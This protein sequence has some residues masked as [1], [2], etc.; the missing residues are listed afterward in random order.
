M[1]KIPRV[2]SKLRPWLRLVRLPAL[3]FA[4][5]A[6]QIGRAYAPCAL[7]VMALAGPK[8]PG[9]LCLLGA[10]A[11]SFAFFDFQPGLRFLA[12]AILTF[13][14]NTAFYD[15]R[16]YTRPDFHGASSVMVTTLVQSVYLLARPL[17]LTVIFILS[18][19]VQWGACRL[20]QPLS[21]KSS[22]PEGSRRAAALLLLSACAALIPL[23]S[24]G[25]SLGRALLSAAALLLSCACSSAPSAAALGLA[26][27]LAADLAGANIQM[28]CTAAFA[29]GCPL[30]WSA[31]SRRWLAGPLFALGAAAVAVL[32]EA[33]KPLVFLYET[34]SGTVLFLLLPR[35]APQKMPQPEPSLPAPL[36]RQLSQS[37]AAFR[38]LYDSFFRGTAPAPPEN[39]SVIFD[40]AAEQVCRKCV[41][42]STCWHQNYNATYNA[43]ND[44]CPALLQR[45]QALAQDFPIHFTSRCVHLQDF[46][47]ALN[48]ELRS[49]L[50][51]QQYH[52]RLLAARRLAQEQYAQ[53]GDLL[54][55]TSAVEAMT[56]TPIG[57]R[58]GSA[59]RPREGCRVCGDQ[60][61]V[62]E[63]GSTLYLLLSDGMGSGE[64][65]HREAAMTVRL[66]Q[67][68]LQS[69]IDPTPALKTLNAALQLRSEDGG[70]FTTID[71]LALQRQSGSAVLYKYGAAPS[72]LK[73]SGTVTRFT[74]AS[75][76]AGLQSS[77]QG[78]ETSRFSLPGGSF[79]VMVSDGI[80]D[81]SD[82]E[83]LQN[84]L[85]GWTGKD[86]AALTNL[87][88]S[89]SRSR[90]GLSD[91]CAVLVVH[92]AP[93][94]G[95]EKISV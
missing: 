85:A 94:E 16:V 75:L 64:G 63:V 56:T 51:R 41:L 25:F 54:A 74:A 59:L 53:L 52:R 73:R 40:Q 90:R 67:Q 76:P 28:L 29:V 83:W 45:G 6:A 62:F 18:L 79:F 3:V 70:G 2:P 33:D 14:V 24:S 78:P 89:E 69:G 87:I 1:F 68:F 80:A 49:F 21:E 84:L 31:R 48:A 44:A 57:Y 46:L 36:Q 19:A 66:L 65:A 39:P 5:S 32:F 58:I 20:L 9:F 95:G 26:V 17:S 30:A 42:C 38:E 11:G 88:L 12:S 13:S 81:E 10:A 27:G 60:L 77:A 23:E 35:Q 15:T 22:S 82:D 92:L 34:L 50:L 91:D 55:S 61:A 47:S 43:F 72:Y 93:P 7:A 37:A 8:L 86:A 4:L 71:L